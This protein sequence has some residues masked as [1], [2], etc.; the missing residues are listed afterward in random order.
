MCE[1]FD[2]DRQVACVAPDPGSVFS[3]CR[4]SFFL[5]ASSAVLRKQLLIRTVKSA[6]AATVYDA[7]SQ[8]LQHRQRLTV[9][10]LGRRCRLSPPLHANARPPITHLLFAVGL[11][12]TWKLSTCLRSL[13]DV[14]R[15]DKL[16]N[17]TIKHR[18]Q[19]DNTF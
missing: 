2:T 16:R 11:K 19:L 6:S 7:Q 14:T 10:S 4:K 15:L 5:S 18:S 17:V 8:Q 9:E 1:M 13:L 3:R 12:D